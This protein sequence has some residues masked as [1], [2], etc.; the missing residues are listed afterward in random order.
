MKRREPSGRLSLMNAIPSAV[1]SADGRTIGSSAPGIS[2]EEFTG[3]RTSAT[4][5]PQ[6]LAAC[7]ASQGQKKYR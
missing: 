2:T 3:F 1:A 6:S 4:T 5:E 7:Q